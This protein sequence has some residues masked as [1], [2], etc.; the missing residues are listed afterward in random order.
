MTDHAIRA[1]TAEDLLAAAEIYAHFVNQTV[2]TFDTTPPTVEDWQCKADDLAARGLPF[3]VLALAGTVAGFAYAAPYRPKAAYRQT[4]ENSIY[5]SPAWLGK[6]LGKPLLTALLAACE[7]T[8]AREMIAVIADAGNDASVRLH[9][10]L[11]FTEV[12]R[13]RR[14]GYKLDRWVD[15]I[16][17]QRSL[18][19]GN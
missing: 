14:V 3:L 10:A 13:L 19:N 6:G 8:D 18:A 12:G 2:V 11:G 4:V 16:L 17:L 1:A 5:L 15:T 9:Q 7:Q